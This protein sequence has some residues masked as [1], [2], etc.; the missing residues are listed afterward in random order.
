MPD[1][2]DGVVLRRPET[3]EEALELP[4]ALRRAFDDLGVERGQPF[5]IVHVDRLKP[6]GE[7]VEPGLPPHNGT[8]TSR[9]AAIHV[10]PRAG[11]LRR[12]VLDAVL[13]APAGLT[14]DEVEVAADMLGSTV[15]PRVVELI[16]GGFL[17]ETLTKRKTRSG[18]DAFVLVAGPRGRENVS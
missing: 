6:A 2:I 16:A 12:R 8:E 14:R 18:E 9:D 1:R 15:R 13:A 10:Y 7:Y 4:T 5:L 17:V 3:R 11:T